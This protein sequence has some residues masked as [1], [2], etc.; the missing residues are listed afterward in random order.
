MRNSGSLWVIAAIMLLL[1]IYVFQIVKAVSHSALPRTRL[2]ITIAYWA[3]SAGAI[4]LML[5]LP[6][7]NYENWPKTIRT[8]TFAIMIGL[9]MSKLVASLFFAIDDFRRG[10]TW[11]FNRIFGSGDA[12]GNNGEGISRSAFLSWLGL[13]VGGGLFGTLLYGFSN[14]YS[15]NVIRQKL[16]YNNLPTAFK[17]L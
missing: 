4:T 9:F 15:Y 5:L 13:G 3:V 14:K 17:G 10:G 8:Y 16:S 1:D 2:I 11:V 6:Y 12:P 7:L